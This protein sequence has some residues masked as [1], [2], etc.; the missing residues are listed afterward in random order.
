[1]D[2][3]ATTGVNVDLVHAARGTL[4]LYVYPRTGVPGE[5]IPP[6]WMETPGAF[7]CTA[8]NCAFRERRGDFGELGASVFG[9][10]AQDFQEQCEFAQRER[11]PYPLLNDSGLRLAGA[12]DLPTFEAAGLR[13][14]R[15]LTLV[16]NAGRIVK[17]FYPVF[18][19][20]QHAQEV[21]AW[22]SRWRSGPS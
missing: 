5:P 1:V 8:E 20:D 13:L 2:L 4:V 9:L 21:I 19:P 15:R 11:I 16:A 7:G 3:P 14:Y 22:L 10:S 17:A 6:G 18:P 12:L